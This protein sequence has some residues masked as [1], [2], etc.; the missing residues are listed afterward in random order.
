[1]LSKR[2]PKIGLLGMMH[3]IYDE[4]QPGIT[5]KQEKYAKDVVSHL[6]G[7]AEV[8]FPGAS[9][10]R[11]DIEANTREFVN[12]DVDGIM[13]MSLLYCPALWAVD[14][15]RVNKL[16]LLIANTQ[17]VPSVTSNWNWSDLTTNQC[18]HGAQDIANVIRRHGFR[19]S[20][21]TESWDTEAFRRYF[22]D[23]AC[24]AKAAKELGRSRIAVFGRCAGMGD[25]LG[26][27]LAFLRILGA[28]ANH[29]SLGE[30]YKRMQSVKEAEVSDQVAEDKRNFKLDPALT[31]ESHSYA[32][33][34]QLGFER[35][36]NEQGYDAF[37]AQCTTFHEDGRFEQLPLL[38]ASNLLA[39]GFGYAGEGDTNTVYL[40][41]L[42][43]LIAENPHFTEMYSLDFTRD[44]AF[45]SHMGEGNWKIARQDRP[46]KL[47]DRPLEI[48]NLSNP[49]TL[50]FS[51][52][53]G[54]A[55]LMSLTGFDSNFRLICS[56]GE[57]LDT[58]ELPNVP[59]PYFHFRP[60]HGIRKAMDD[61][62]MNGGTH[63]Q[64]LLPGD[65]SRR[66]KFFCEI[67][68]VEYFEV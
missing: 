32:A 60:E 17:P 28:E 36:L 44:S 31:K 25:L 26:D 57:V 39:K 52:E 43:H 12:Q 1:M 68:G 40:T 37:T 56:R 21:I 35:F 33:R 48:A 15:L 19:P 41:M 6:S 23:W 55:T 53:P 3:G 8:I 9:K 65:H 64:V 42:G 63:H 10:T 29:V 49:P 13:I 38:G 4:A 50:V 30:V 58:P 18:I 45:M 47:I 24:A 27:D 34:L 16:P 22:L 46:I 7:V 61:W 20:I 66:V 14:F 2:M 62:L 11:H 5:T 54:P 51:A 59:M 67:M